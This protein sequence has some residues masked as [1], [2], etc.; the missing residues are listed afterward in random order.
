M[1]YDKL[2][3]SKPAINKKV[4]E[5]SKFMKSG[6]SGGQKDSEAQ[7]VQKQKNQLRNSG[8]VRDAAAL[9]EQFLE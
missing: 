5:A 3:K 2:Q 1:M 9:F 7:S 6:T 8:K 4:A